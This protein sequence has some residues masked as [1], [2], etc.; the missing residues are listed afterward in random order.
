MSISGWIRIRSSRDDWEG[1]LY[2]LGESS[3]LGIS[4]GA[5]G[6]LSV[7]LYVTSRIFFATPSD[8]DCE[9]RNTWLQ[10]QRTRELPQ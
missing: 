4:G 8:V 10:T 9:Y 3:Q 7:R 2:L 6:E 5:F 1:T